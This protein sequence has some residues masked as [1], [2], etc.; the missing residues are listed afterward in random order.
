MQEV[1]EKQWQDQNVA[2]WICVG[3]DYTANGKPTEAVLD[4]AAAPRRPCDAPSV[5]L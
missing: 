1:A 3:E 2:R 4:G 5:A